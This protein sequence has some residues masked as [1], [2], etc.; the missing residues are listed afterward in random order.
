MILIIILCRSYLL[1]RLDRSHRRSRR[2]RALCSRGVPR[3]VGSHS[4]AN[5]NAL[6]LFV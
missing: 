5:L 3:M 6:N 2:R 1:F 4:K